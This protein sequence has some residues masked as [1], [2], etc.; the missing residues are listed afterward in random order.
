MVRLIAHH[1]AQ[2]EKEYS[3]PHRTTGAGTPHRGGSSRRIRWKACP[4][5]RWLTRYRGRDLPVSTRSRCTSGDGGPLSAHAEPI[6]SGPDHRRPHTTRRGGARVIRSAGPVGRNRHR[7]PLGRR[8]D[9]SDGGVLSMGEHDWEVALETNLMAAVRV[10]RAL[11]P[12]MKSQALVRLSTS[13]PSN[14][15][16]L[17]APRF[18]TRRAKRR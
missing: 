11:I 5:Y 2:L 17:S 4:G 12:A 7:R 14:A 13:V 18:P 10:D 8:G 9:L 16:S 1:R 6:A 3:C 15:D